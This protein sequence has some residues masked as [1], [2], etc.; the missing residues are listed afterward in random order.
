MQL[1]ILD[2]SMALYLETSN[3]PFLLMRALVQVQ[4]RAPGTLGSMNVH[5]LKEMQH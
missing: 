1:I 2:H 5:K 4:E 3:A